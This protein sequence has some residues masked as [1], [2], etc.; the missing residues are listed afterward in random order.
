M[1][2]RDLPMKGQS[3]RSLF[4]KDVIQMKHNLKICVSKEPKCGGVVACRNV[5]LRNK[6]LT[7]LLGPKEQVMIIVP[8]K[9]VQTVAITEIMDGG[10]SYEAVRS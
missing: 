6:V 4:R 8:G 1:I 2:S 7:W 9:S 10:V 3:R 5:S